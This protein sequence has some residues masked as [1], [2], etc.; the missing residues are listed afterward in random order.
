V[1]TGI[2]IR[3]FYH[4]GTRAI[5]RIF[6]FGISCLGRGCGLRLLLV[7]IGNLINH[8]HGVKREHAYTLESHDAGLLLVRFRLIV[9]L[10][11]HFP[12]SLCML[13]VS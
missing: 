12:Y 9:L 7:F 13:F 11:Y 8:T 1:D 5:V 6:V 4:Y 2:F 3:N 10:F